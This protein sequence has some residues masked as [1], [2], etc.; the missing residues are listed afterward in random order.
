MGATDSRA[1]AAIATATIATTI[2]R[3][4]VE[5]RHGRLVSVE[6]LKGHCACNLLQLA[7]QTLDLCAKLRLQ[8]RVVRLIR[9]KMGLGLIQRRQRVLDASDELLFVGHLLPNSTYQH[10]Y[11]Q[12]RPKY[13]V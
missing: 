8:L 7:M 10:A 9:W 4:S 2:G 13:T 6:F 11:H 5:E 12:P 1:I 3:A